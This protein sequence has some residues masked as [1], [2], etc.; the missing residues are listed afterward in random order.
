MSGNALWQFGWRD[1][2]AIGDA[3]IDAQHR[4]FFV[5]AEQI[6][7]ALV[8]D[9]PRARILDYCATFRADL[10]THFRDE[11]ALMTTLGFPQLRDHRLEHSRLLAQT[12]ETCHELEH[13]TCLI[14]CLLG[15]RSLLERLAEHIALQDA[16]IRAFIQAAN[17]E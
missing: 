12:E 11:E 8:S 13:A 10:E 7:A 5:E 2:L 6:R 16:R 3:A 9:Q 14:D 4:A 15:T 17:K 1:D